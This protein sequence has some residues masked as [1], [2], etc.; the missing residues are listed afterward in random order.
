MI[1]STRQASA[2]LAP[3]RSRRRRT[4]LCPAGS[5]RSASS[6]RRNTS[7]SSRS[8]LRAELVDP[9]LEMLQVLLAEGRS[10]TDECRERQRAPLAAA[11]ANGLVDHDTRQPAEDAEATVESADGVKRRDPGILDRVLGEPLVT[12][13]AKRLMHKGR[14][15]TPDQRR[16]CPLVSGAQ[17]LEQCNFFWMSRML[18]SHD[19]LVSLDVQGGR[20][21]RARRPRQ[22]QASALEWIGRGP[23]GQDLDSGCRL[24]HSP[25]ASATLPPDLPIHR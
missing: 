9:R 11:A 2:E 24:L 21:Q 10:R 14:V 4:D 22:C 15:V 19:R 8:P 18:A 12:Q 5:A 25:V 16:P 1:C 23:A 20:L 7:C 17:C 3:P 13:N 6:N